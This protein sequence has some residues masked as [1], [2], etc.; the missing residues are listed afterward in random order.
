VYPMSISL[1]SVTLTPRSWSMLTTGPTS[2]VSAGPQ[3]RR[4]LSPQLSLSKS[5]HPVPHNLCQLSGA[6]ICLCGSHVISTLSAL[7]IPSM[8]ISWHTFATRSTFQY[9]S[10]LISYMGAKFGIRNVRRVNALHSAIR[11]GPDVFSTW[12]RIAAFMSL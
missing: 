4:T 6:W 5:P 3:P 8:N 12:L 1:Q 7:Q 2:T 10:Q 11:L 9:S